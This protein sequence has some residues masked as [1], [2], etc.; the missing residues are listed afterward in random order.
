MKRQYGVVNAER[1]MHKKRIWNIFMRASTCTG[2]ER[3]DI[4]AAFLFAFAAANEELDTDVLP[5]PWTLLSQYDCVITWRSD[6]C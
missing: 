5:V 1:F 6:Y 4:N 2:V 3:D